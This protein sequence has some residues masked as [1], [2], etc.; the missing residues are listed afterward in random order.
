MPDQSTRALITSARTLG[1]GA[2]SFQLTDDELLRLCAVIAVD[3][4]LDSLVADFANPSELANGYY[5]TALVWFKQPVGIVR[6]ETRF[7]QLQDAIEDFA[8]YFKALCEV[9]KRRLKYQ[10]ILSYQAVPPLETIVPR[11]LLEFGLHSAETL[12]SWLVWRKWLYDID[13]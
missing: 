10:A 4:G 12:A 6:F 1:G 2:L 5:G 9:H 13:N 8:T 3:L 7:I 11:S